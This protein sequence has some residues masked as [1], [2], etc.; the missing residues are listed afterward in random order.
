VAISGN[1]REYLRGTCYNNISTNTLSVN[2]DP[3]SP[4]SV[5]TSCGITPP[6]GQT[7]SSYRCTAVFNNYSNDPNHIFPTPA[8]NLNLSSSATGYSSSYWTD[9]NA[10]TSTANNSLPVDVSSGGSTVYD[11]DIFFNNS[12]AWIKLKNS[13]FS[14]P[15]SL[16]N[17][18]PLNIAAYDADDDVNQRYFIM[19]SVDNDPGL[20]TAQTINTGTA[21]VSIKGWKADSY[22]RQTALTPSIFTQYVKSRKEHQT[23]SDLSSIEKDG[24]YVWQTGIPFPEITAVPSRFNDFNVLLIVADTVSINMTDFNPSKSIAIIASTIN[25]SSTSQY[26]KG[27]FIAQTINTSSSLTQGLKIKGNLVTFSGFVNGREW[28]DNSQPS[29]FIVFDQ[30]Q[31]INLLPYLSTASYEWRQIQ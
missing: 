2:I 9:A 4:T 11:K 20:V 24:I 16:T 6:A 10:C 17:V 3:D 14:S 15:G 21:P 12:T 26:A 19:N 28:P 7:R 23:I 18:L 30:E 29:V 1:L 5:S 8:Q 13:S 31:Y 25:F 22:T 27:I